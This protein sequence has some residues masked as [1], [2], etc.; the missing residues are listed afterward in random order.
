MGSRAVFPR[1][2]AD[3]EG[4]NVLKI[5]SN[6]FL[7]LLRAHT[8]IKIGFN[9]PRWT[10]GIISSGLRP[11]RLTL[12]KGTRSWSEILGCKLLIFMGSCPF[13]DLLL[14]HLCIKLGFFVFKIC[15]R[16]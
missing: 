6:V 8:W 15:G 11:N 1:V 5:A 3:I 9:G 2:V 4:I 12:P 10:R 14:I 16:L 7:G 13:P